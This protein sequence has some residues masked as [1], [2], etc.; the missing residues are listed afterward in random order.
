MKKKHTYT[1]RSFQKVYREGH[2]FS[3]GVCGIQLCNNSQKG[4]HW[5]VA[6]SSKK[7]RRAHERNRIKRIL[8]E[9]VYPLLP[10]IRPTYDIIFV[11]RGNKE[12]IVFDKVKK[13]IETLL[14]QRKNIFL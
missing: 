11:F 8:R 6:V 12:D 2:F 4:F 3:Y 5:G 14:N 10:F 9:A 13:D 7:W 1:L